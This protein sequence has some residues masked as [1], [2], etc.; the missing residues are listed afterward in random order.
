[1]N[2]KDGYQS[3]CKKCDNIR[4]EVWRLCNPE[5]AKIHASNAEKNRLNNEA[6]RQYRKEA[7]KLPHIKASRN[8]A[9][10]KRRAAKLNRTPKWLTEHD[11]TV[12]KAFYAV[13]QMLS[14][15]NEEI[16][17]VDHDI[18]LQAKLA[19]GLHVP[20][21]LRLMRGIENETKQNQYY[22]T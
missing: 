21:N 2:S 16:W 8:A 13:A 1:M 6:R 22:I 11:Y 19:S 5:L 3:H 17:H 14:R 9:Y 7:R 20:S 4:K 15:V 18:P 10:A 12:I